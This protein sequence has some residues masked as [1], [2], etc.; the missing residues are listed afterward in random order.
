AL[1]NRHDHLSPTILL[2]VNDLIETQQPRSKSNEN[3]TKS[4]KLTVILSLITVWLQVR[5]LP[6]LPMRSIVNIHDDCLC[7]ANWLASA[8]SLGQKA[9]CSRIDPL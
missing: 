5:V 2:G 9:Y 6:G 3:A 1:H 4:T 8:K 7:D